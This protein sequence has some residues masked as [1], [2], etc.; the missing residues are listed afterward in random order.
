MQM[1]HV[2]LICLMKTR[3]SS[4]TFAICGVF[5]GLRTCPLSTHAETHSKLNQWDAVETNQTCTVINI[6]FVVSNTWCVFP[7]SYQLGFQE[8]WLSEKG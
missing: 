7:W 4:S 5:Y 1:V 3:I 8:A 2:F 6:F